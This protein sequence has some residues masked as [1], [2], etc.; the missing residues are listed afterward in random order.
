MAF[1]YT[2]WNQTL[3]NKSYETK[4]LNL[5]TDYS[6]FIPII[7]TAMAHAQREI[8][9]KTYL[10]GFERHSSFTNSLDYKPSNLHADEIPYFFGFPN[11][12]LRPFTM[13]R[14]NITVDEIDTSRRLMTYIANF[15]KTG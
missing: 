6:F 15:A 3:G 9:K 11:S 10:L 7:N 1:I 12:V 5:D 4:L 2:D 14:T 13:S 8:G